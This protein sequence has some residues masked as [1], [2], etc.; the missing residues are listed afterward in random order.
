MTK[1]TKQQN[2]Q[3]CA[4]GFTDRFTEGFKIPSTAPET[5]NFFKTDSIKTMCM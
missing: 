2:L 5:N 4:K 1:I 3:Q